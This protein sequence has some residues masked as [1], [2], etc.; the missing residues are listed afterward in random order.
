MLAGQPNQ[1]S[2]MADLLLFTKETLLCAYTYIDELLDIFLF[3]KFFNKG[4]CFIFIYTYI[5]LNIHDSVL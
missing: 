5:I 3:H 1:K 4:G 2:H